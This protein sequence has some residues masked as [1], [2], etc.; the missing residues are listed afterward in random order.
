VR[1]DPSL[2]EEAESLAGISALLDSKDLYFQLSPRCFRESMRLE[3]AQTA[4]GA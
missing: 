3:P 4:D 1:F 2:R